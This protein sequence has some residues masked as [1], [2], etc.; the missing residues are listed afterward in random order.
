MVRLPFGRT[1][2]ESDTLTVM[3]LCNPIP[4]LSICEST[5]DVRKF[6]CCI[7]L[8]FCTAL[9]IHFTCRRS[10][11]HLCISFTF[12]FSRRFCPKR[13]TVIHTY[14]HTLTAVAAV[15][16]A[17]QHRSS[18]G[19]SVLPED[20]STC[21]PGEWSQRPSD[22]ETLALVLSHGRQIQNF[23]LKDLGDIRGSEPD[24]RGVMS[25]TCLRVCS[26]D[27][28]KLKRSGVSRTDVTATS[29]VRV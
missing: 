11:A 13:L 2:W 29:P 26:L 8:Y 12:T 4:C 19:F 15:Q 20:T 17:D 1:W 18:L 28:T 22:N 23:Q 5:L 27:N 10:S 3:H 24:R 7:D 16:G 25:V 9:T 6:A 21:R 14:I